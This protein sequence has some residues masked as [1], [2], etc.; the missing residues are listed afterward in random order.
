MILVDEKERGL[1]GTREQVR[2]ANGENRRGYGVKYL[3]LRHMVRMNNLSFGFW[4]FIASLKKRKASTCLRYGLRLLGWPKLCLRPR[5]RP[6][7]SPSISI[8]IF[9][10]NLWLL[11]LLWLAW[12]AREGKLSCRNRAC[13]R[14]TA[15][16]Q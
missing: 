8:L 15:R 12:L 1:D 9:A 5:P 10:P 13:T 6:Q 14:M 4:M 3:G 2:S 11:L 7:P 16:Q